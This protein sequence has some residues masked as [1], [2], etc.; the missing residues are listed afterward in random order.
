MPDPLLAAIKGA[1]GQ[2]VDAMLF[3][4]CAVDLLRQHYYSNLRGTPQKRDAGIDGIAGADADPEFILVATTAKPG[5]T[6]GER[7]C[8][9]EE[10]E[11]GALL[12]LGE[13]S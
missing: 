10:R 9:R 6:E 2:R 3:E 11:L 5:S 12:N 8:S 4:E 13:W 1:I 7:G